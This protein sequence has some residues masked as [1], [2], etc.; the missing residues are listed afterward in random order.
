M[1]E[2]RLRAVPENLHRDLL[3]IMDF[4]T[5]TA[6]EFLRPML[7]DILDDY[8]EDIK[9]NMSIGNKKHIR[10]TGVSPKKHQQLINIASHLGITVEQLIK[11]HMQKV[12]EEYPIKFR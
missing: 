1:Q 12:V 6:P 9:K 11:T 7:N 10:I 3:D 2:I 8:S 5:K 4:E